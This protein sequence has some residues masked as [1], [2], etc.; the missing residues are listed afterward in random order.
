MGSR[1]YFGTRETLAE[2]IIMVMG[3]VARGT[4]PSSA[5]ILRIGTMLEKYKKYIG[6]CRRAVYIAIA[7]LE[8]IEPFIRFAD[9]CSV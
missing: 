3:P 7:Y 9:E 1:D 2:V 8:F 4:F 5:T 6:S